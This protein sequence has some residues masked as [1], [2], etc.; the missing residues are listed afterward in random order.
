MR[1]TTEEVAHIARLSRIELNSQEHAAFEDELSAIL[2]FVAKLNEVS[3]ANSEPITGGAEL[4][5]I[6]REDEVS[7]ESP[8]PSDGALV[9]AAPGKRS[10][11]IAVK[12][13]FDRE[14]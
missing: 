13:V 5:N 3:T 7:G 8:V 6:T 9:A 4:M 11:Y 12:A 1:I 14:V 2:D 10:G